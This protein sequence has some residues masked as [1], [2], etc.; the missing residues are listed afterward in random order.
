LPW[1][2]AV[3]AFAA[4]AFAAA[5]WLPRP[6]LVATARFCCVVFCRFKKALFLTSK[7]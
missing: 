7:T 1:P 6:P 2:V 5:P 4:L 3:T